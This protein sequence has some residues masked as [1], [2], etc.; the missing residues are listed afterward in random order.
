LIR[1]ARL[2]SAT[3]SICLLSIAMVEPSREALLVAP[4]GTAALLAAGLLAAFDATVPMTTI[5]ACAEV[6]HLLAPLADPLS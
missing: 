2:L 1:H 6:K 4:V 5:A 3:T